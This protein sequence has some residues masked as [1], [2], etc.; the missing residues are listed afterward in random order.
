MAGIIKFIWKKTDLSKSQSLHLL[1]K[2]NICLKRVVMVKCENIEQT[3]KEWRG[4]CKSK[5]VLWL[6]IEDENLQGTKWRTCTTI[7]KQR[8]KKSY[9]IIYKE[10]KQ[11]GMHVKTWGM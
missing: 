1:G 7:N 11:D 9:A 5:D 3:C 8:N 6:H 2:N 10:A 4:L